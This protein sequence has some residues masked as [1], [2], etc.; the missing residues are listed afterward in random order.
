MKL[1]SFGCSF[2]FGSDLADNGGNL[3]ATT[4]SNYTWPAHLAQHLGYEY[5][6]HA[7]PGS[8]NLQIAERILSHSV[9]TDPSFYVIGWTWIDRFDYTDST[10]SR[11]PTQAKWKNWRTIMPIDNSD[12]AKTYYQDLHSEYRDKLCSLM[13][14]KLVIDTLNQKQIPFLMTYMD[15]LLF[16][17]KCN[18]TAAVIDLQNFIQP[19][20]IDFE[21]QSFLEWSRQ[22]N[23]EISTTLHPLEPAHAAAAELMIRA[24]DKQNTSGRDP[25]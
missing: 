11:I 20:M 1:K 23:F 17:Q 18:H 22:N 3:P 9:H 2:I 21:G 4:P 25:V 24:F 15:S 7:R 6:C 12:L 16:D 14:I 10:V 8:G 5:E 13:N 19:Y